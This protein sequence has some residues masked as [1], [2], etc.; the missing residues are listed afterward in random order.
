MTLTS[1][2]VDFKDEGGKCSYGL[3]A[4]TSGGGCDELVQMLLVV[5][6]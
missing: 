6:G 2:Y 4:V 1:L 3:E 5:K